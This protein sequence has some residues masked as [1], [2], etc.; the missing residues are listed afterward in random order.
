[1]RNFFL[2]VNRYSS[3][4]KVNVISTLPS[5]KRSFWAFIFCSW[6]NLEE[7]EKIFKLCQCLSRKSFL[8][9]GWRSFCWCSLRFAHYLKYKVYETFIALFYLYQLTLLL[10]FRL[11]KSVFSVYTREFLYD[12]IMMIFHLISAQKY[13][14][15]S[16]ASLFLL[17]D[18][19]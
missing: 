12:W 3:N 1:M 7:L 14:W 16:W 8:S 9:V 2:R 13:L 17:W 18:M 11:I 15:L 10:F 5:L 19:E 4:L 6:R